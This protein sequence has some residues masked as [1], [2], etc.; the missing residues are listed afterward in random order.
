MQR[1]H[2]WCWV[3]ACLPSSLTKEHPRMRTT[4]PGDRKTGAPREPAKGLLRA[5]QVAA[6][7]SAPASPAWRSVMA[8]ERDRARRLARSF[9]PQ[10]AATSWHNI[11]ERG[12]LR[13]S[14][15]SG[16]GNLM[17]VSCI[18]SVF[19]EPI[20]PWG[21]GR[22]WATR[23]TAAKFESPRWPRMIMCL[24]PWG[25]CQAATLI[26]G[27]GLP[28]FL[29]G[30]IHLVPDR[31]FA[32]ALSV[33]GTLLSMGRVIALGSCTST[34]YPPWPYTCPYVAMRHRYIH[35]ASCSFAKT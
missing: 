29:C 27:C 20:C 14:G 25:V 24:H 16:D 21:S 15:C 30:G 23:Q 1:R 2:R 9:V 4:R 31:G 28:F 12:R 3:H 17:V 18:C 8:A 32:C 6:P 13:C 35:C 34:V 10:R 19:S 7:S 33:H 22:A 11:V 5:P 26:A